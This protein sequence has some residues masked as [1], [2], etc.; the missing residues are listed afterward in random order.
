[1]VTLLATDGQ[2]ILYIDCAWRH[3][4]I[5]EMLKSMVLTCQGVST[6]LVLISSSCDLLSPFPFF[7]D[8]P[9]CAFESFSASYAA[10][11]GTCYLSR[12]LDGR[13]HW[14]YESPR[15]L[16][17]GWWTDISR[18]QILSFSGCRCARQTG[19]LV[20]LYHLPR[21][22]RHGLHPARMSPWR[23]PENVSHGL[24]TYGE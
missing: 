22:D 15:Q 12:Y 23:S 5:A 6:S 4:P 13:T 9:P 16:V 8:L 10:S 17:Q 20:P 18:H 2:S 3:Q 21:A 11:P 7:S 24:V 19:Q 14:N 1:M